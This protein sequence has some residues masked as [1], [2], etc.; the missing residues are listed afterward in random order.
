MPL[1]PSP[2]QTVPSLGKGLGTLPCCSFFL[3]LEQS[4][5]L[6]TC[7]SLLPVSGSR[8][9]GAVGQPPTC[10]SLWD[11][12]VRTRQGTTLLHLLCTGS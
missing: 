3:L 11:S 5:R 12:G 4:P 8:M 10:F 2:S 1:V 6:R 9:E 7:S